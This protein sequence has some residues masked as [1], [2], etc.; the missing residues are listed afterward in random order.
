MWI[1]IIAISLLLVCI[2]RGTLVSNA[3][4]WIVLGLAIDILAHTG[5]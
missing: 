3:L 4:G 5:W 2:V 1:A